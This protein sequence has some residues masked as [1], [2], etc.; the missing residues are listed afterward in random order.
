MC[1]NLT[2]SLTSSLYHTANLFLSLTFF[3]SFPYPIQKANPLIITTNFVR[4]LCHNSFMRYFLR[5][6]LSLNGKRTTPSAYFTQVA[7]FKCTFASYFFLPQLMRQVKLS[8]FVRKQK[9]MN[10]SSRIWKEVFG[11]SSDVAQPNCPCAFS[12]RRRVLQVVPLQL[13]LPLQFFTFTATTL[14]KY[15]STAAAAPLAEA[16]SNILT[17]NPTR[18]MHKVPTMSRKLDSCRLPSVLLAASATAAVKWKIC[19]T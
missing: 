18:T 5:L 9:K 8:V 13:L 10:F 3:W 6:C 15:Y 2:S 14:Q 4:R 12:W 1:N 17:T 7:H 19:Y 11:R 16:S